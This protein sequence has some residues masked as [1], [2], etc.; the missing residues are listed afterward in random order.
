LAPSSQP[1]DAPDGAGF[2]IDGACDPRFEAVRSTFEANFRQGLE[3]GAAVSVVVDGRAVVDLVGGWANAARTTPW[4]RDT[5][6]NVWSTTKGIA[7][8]AFAMLVDRGQARYEDP[9]ARYWPEFAAAGKAGVTIVQLLSHQAGLCGF[10]EPAQLDDLLSGSRAAARLAAQT[11]L[12]PLGAGSGYHAITGGI[13][14]TELFR[15]IDGRSLRRFVADELRAARGFD[16]SIGLDRAD[17]DRRAEIVA[18][19][20]SSAQIASLTEAQRA[21]LANPPL[22]PAYPN[23]E[24]W[25]DADLPSANGHSNAHALARLYA[26][27]AGV[28][29]DAPLVSPR[30]LAQA[31]A[32]QTAGVDRVLNVR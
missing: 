22:D 28:G 30:T 5:V 19:P 12:W 8:M 1:A 16:V 17:A 10:A 25:R 6:V 23:R 2:A 7:A 3:L 20:M 9:V 15:R 29:G 26:A 13:L 31:T 21:A 11:P 24:D 14:A 4:T 18:P 32:L 27:F